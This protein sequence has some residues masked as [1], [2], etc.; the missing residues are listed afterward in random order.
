MGF[1]VV[2]SCVHSLPTLESL[3]YKTVNLEYLSW[4]PPPL[5][6]TCCFLLLTSLTIQMPLPA[7]PPELSS[8]PLFLS[9]APSLLLVSNLE[10][11]PSGLK[12]LKAIIHINGGPGRMTD[13]KE[14]I[15]SQ[16]QGAAWTAD[17]TAYSCT[18]F[19]KRS[20]KKKGSKSK[21]MKRMK[22]I[23]KNILFKL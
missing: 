8:L 19:V 17:P 9:P 5:C 13:D 4:R 3:L 16:K 15:L 22:W 21:W 7:C 6:R 20:V 18:T 10:S 12:D 2:D 23:K 11:N 14:Y 1:E